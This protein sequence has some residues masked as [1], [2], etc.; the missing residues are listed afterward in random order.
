MSSFKLD[1]DLLPINVAVYKRENDNFVLLS[2][3]KE[4][5]K[6]KLYSQ[7]C[8]LGCYITDIFPNAK[9]SGLFE[10][11]QRVESTGNSENINIAVYLGSN[12][13]WQNNEVVKLEEGVVA[14][15]NKNCCL[16]S[17]LQNRDYQLEQE[18]NEAEKLLEHQKKMFQHIMENSEAISVQGYNEN[19]EVI[20]WNKA[21]ERIYGYSAE[22]ADGKKIENLIIPDFM[23]DHVHKSIEDWMH[24]GIVVPASELTLEDKDGVDV[25]V[26][27]QHNMIKVDTKHYEM[28]CVDIDLKEVKQLQQELLTQRNFLR[29]IF[30]VIPD[31]IWIQD[32]EGKYLACNSIFEQ[33]IGAKEAELIGQTSFDITNSNIATLFQEREFRTNL[34]ESRV[35]HSLVFADNS[36]SGLFETIKKPMTDGS[37]N[38]TGILGI[39]RDITEHKERELQLQTFAHFDTLT[40]LANRTLFMERLT[41]LTKQREQR[42][43]KSAVLFI[44]LD[45]FKEVNDTKGHSVGDQVLVSVAQRIKSILRKGDTLARFGGDEF[46]VLLGQITSVSD[47]SSVAVAILEV[48]REPLLIEH[49][50]FHL[51]SSIGIAI[52]PDNGHDPESLL[53]FADTAMYKAKENGRDGFEF[54]TK[55]LSNKAV[56]RV[57]LENDLHRA[58]NNSEFVLYYQ[59]QIDAISKKLI[60]AEALIRWDDPYLGLISPYKFISVAEDSGLIVE[61]GRWVIYQAMQDMGSWREKGIAIDTISINLSVKQLNDKKLIS[62]IKHALEQT[63]CHP[64]WV[65]FE[66]NEGY[67][68]T[69]PEQAIVLL[70]KI[71]DLG[72]KISMDDFGTGYSSLAYLKRLPVK[73]LKI[74]QSFVRDIP[75]DRDD[76]AIVKAV[77]LIA[78]SMNLEVIAEGVEE[79]TQ[80]TFL[81]EQGCQYSQGYLY[82]KPMPINQFE[83]YL[84]Q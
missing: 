66:I 84:L 32:V 27:S 16:D 9:Q 30:D 75:G 48:L 19:H 3:N 73:K 7:Q 31:L 28:Y 1:I 29:T 6:T 63:K 49:H 17:R 13:N 76:E 33:F 53:Q 68:M 72:C 37:G 20:Y 41:Q 10:A 56:E 58:L 42:N 35:T 43:L 82:A 47:A 11:M 4:A 40:G 5:Q 22:E 39:S 71:R 46:T 50:Q 15:L 60:G 74:D 81:L 64:E 69:D 59:P 70:E 2:S 80:Q 52:Y 65:E 54:Y 62:T 44:D 21:S 23:R 83:E 78:K 51:S 12:K 8:L 18:L 55:E 14:V 77:I 67:A 36:H 38:I 45:N 34:N 25:H 26:Y 61:I 24:K 57:L 79:E